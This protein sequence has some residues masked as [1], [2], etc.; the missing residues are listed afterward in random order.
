[1]PQ[2]EDENIISKVES[3]K[4]INVTR[5]DE[6]SKQIT[7]AK[8]TLTYMLASEFNRGTN[9]YE[10]K[11]KQGLPLDEITKYKNG[12]L[13]KIDLGVRNKT[14]F[15]IGDPI[16]PTK[17]RHI[18][19]VSGSGRSGSTFLGDLLSRYPGTFYSFEGER[20]KYPPNPKTK[21]V[22]DIVQQVFKCTPEIAYFNYEKYTWDQPWSHLKPNFRF[23]N[24]YKSFPQH[25]SSFYMKALYDATCPLFPIRL[26]KTILLPVEETEALLNDSELSKTLKV[27]VLFRDPRGIMQSLTKMA[28]MRGEDWAK[29][30]NSPATL[31]QKIESDA[32]TAFKLK[33]KY[34]GK[35]VY[36]F[37]TP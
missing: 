20:L 2:T 27:I 7:E 4:T 13:L 14:T 30:A 9:L 6:V 11:S 22:P 33:E 15:N 23:S 12:K 21:K 31:C 18:L 8:E 16:P 32:L 3:S 35:Y 25:D 24:V 26:M 28:E 10:T 29:A 17:A 37:T 1:M 19:L 36:I 34:P 5:N